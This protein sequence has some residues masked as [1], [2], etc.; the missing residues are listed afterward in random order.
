MARE[1]YCWRCKTEIPMLDEEEWARIS[2]L[3]AKSV[4]PETRQAAL[5]LYEEMTGFR[6][7]NI[8]AIWHH[9]IANY[10][11]SCGHCGKPLRTPKAK[12]CA[13]CGATSRNR[14]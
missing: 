14:A 9:R 10:G 7:T 3:L 12:F 2:P 4:E 6:E 11:S 1:I 8:N 13:E 5:Q